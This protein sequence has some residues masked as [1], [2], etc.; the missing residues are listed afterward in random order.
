LHLTAGA[1]ETQLEIAQ[2]GTTIASA[3]AVARL[4]AAYTRLAC[5]ANTALVLVNKR[6]IDTWDVAN[7]TG[8]MRRALTFLCRAVA[9]AT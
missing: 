6:A 4:I 2:A 9:L 7:L 8:P 3:L 1:L 5:I